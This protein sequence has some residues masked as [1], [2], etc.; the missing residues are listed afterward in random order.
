MKTN[1][2]LIQFCNILLLSFGHN[3]NASRFNKVPTL[4]HYF[5]S[6]IEE[7]WLHDGTIFC[8][9]A[10]LF[11][12]KLKSRY[13]KT[14]EKV[15]KCERN[16]KKYLTHLHR[17]L[18]DQNQLKSEHVAKTSEANALPSRVRFPETV[19]K[20]KRTYTLSTLAVEVPI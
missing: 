6:V 10:L 16:A 2:H 5:S 20:A 19:E 4:V 13:I 11:G 7:I 8:I 1:Q 15:M 18:I 12:N 9:P 3:S 17:S 14:M